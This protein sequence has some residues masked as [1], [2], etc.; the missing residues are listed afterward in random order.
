[1]ALQHVAVCV[2]S[3]LTIGSIGGVAYNSL[4]R[5][6]NTA[7]E[8]EGTKPQDSF[9]SVKVPELPPNIKS[10]SA[11]AP[12]KDPVKVVKST[13][14]FVSGRIQAELTCTNN[15]HPGSNYDDGKHVIVCQEDGHRHSFGWVKIQRNRASECEWKE[16]TKS[17]VCTSQNSKLVPVT[18]KNLKHLKTRNAIQIS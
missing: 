13:Y 18:L 16:G 8:P 2:L 12:E 7:F 5:Q 10:L 15:L 9:P 1:M 4:Q 17:Y 3:C 14:K 6:T 11:V